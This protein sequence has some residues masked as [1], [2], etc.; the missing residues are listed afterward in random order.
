MLGQ[1]IVLVALSTLA[2]VVIGVPLGILASRRPR[3][4]GP[5]I[6]AANIVQTVPSL[7][8]FGFLIPVPFIGGVGARTALVVLILYGL[9]PV[10]R[11]TVAGLK[12]I[13]RA[14]VESGLA[15]G[16]TPRQL[17]LQV[18]LPLA[19]PS[20]IAG[21]R[22]ATVVGVGAATIAAAIGAGGLGEYIFRGLSMADPAVILAGAVP[23][24]ALALIADGSLTWLERRLS[25]RRR[26]A[27]SQMRHAAAG[28]AVLLGLAAGSAALAGSGRDAIVVGSKNFTEQLILGELL[29]QTVER[30][31]GLEVDRRLN[32]GGTFL[33][34]RALRAGEI[35]V[36]VEYTGT[37]LTAIFGQPVRRDPA[38]VYEAVRLA[39][40]RTGRALFPPLGFNNTFAVLVRDDDANRLGLRTIGDLATNAREWRAGFGYEFI[41]RADGYQGLVHTYGL[42]FAAP[43]R[44]MDL[45]L[46]YRALAEGQVDVIAGDMTSGL[47]QALNL[48]VLED[49]RHYFPPYDA[50]PVVHSQTLL[51]VPA[52]GEALDHLVG[53]ISARDM[54]SMNMSVDVRRRDVTTV[55]REFLASLR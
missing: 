53:R 11:T 33:C 2:A 30:F 18:E 41:E 4:G 49:D 12:G 54:Q 22:V 40:A 48:R 24:A 14:V 34:D 3:I 46:S 23:A 39:Y 35:D 26:G 52:L 44:V 7:A 16:M 10:I 36:Y 47:I 17:L 28:G 5:L 27:R 15:M 55:A 42:Q 6:A 9:L 45:T 29:A 43:P 50:T 51:R 19:L 31:G 32:L 13:D 37:A 38:A 1:H 25:A 21:V 8:M 20:I